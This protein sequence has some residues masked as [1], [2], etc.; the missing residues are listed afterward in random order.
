MFE[1]D[2]RRGRSRGT[3]SDAANSVIF[4]G[5]LMPTKGLGWTVVALA[6]VLL[7]SAPAPGADRG[8]ARKAYD[9]ATAAFGLGHYAEAA[10]KYETAFSIHP[11]PA[12]LYN[13]AQAYRL[14][15]NRARAL[16]LYRNYLRLYPDRSNAEEARSQVA[17][18]TKA[19]DDER[20]AVVVPPPSVA[21]A[22]T[23]APMP[24]AVSPATVTL[25]PAPS[26][27][28]SPVSQSVA[29]AVTSTPSDAPP[30]AAGSR[31]WLW[32]AVGAAVVV[33]GTVAILLATR[34]EKFPDA[35]YG[36]AMGN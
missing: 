30:P 11:D 20:R 24:A 26:P 27:S 25:S 21:P 32:I 22:P 28:P 10:E 31:T 23:P 34:G 12:L 8:E 6:A 29:A 19:I 2:V 3:P 14:A 17:A 7:L 18:L 5:G 36:T 9:A 13:C 16:E 15:G 4:W 35:T 33:G 1:G